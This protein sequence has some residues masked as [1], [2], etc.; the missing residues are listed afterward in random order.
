MTNVMGI[1]RHKTYDC[2]PCNKSFTEQFFLRKHNESE[3]KQCPQCKYE[4]RVPSHLRSHIEEVH[5]NF[6][7]Q[8][9]LCDYQNYR[10]SQMRK[11]LALTHDN[12]ISITSINQPTN[13]LTQKQD[14]QISISYKINTSERRYTE[15]AH[16]PFDK[17]YKCKH[18][19]A[20]YRS[21]RSLRKHIQAIHSEVKY[22]CSHCEYEA[23]R[24]DNLKL[25]IQAVHEK[26]RYQCPLCSYYVSRVSRLKEH[27]ALKH[28]SQISLRVDNQR[29]PF[30]AICELKANNKFGRNIFS[31]HY[32]SIK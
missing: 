16:K 30:C 32:F 1:R 25:H 13:H 14:T 24:L 26:L 20:Q 17:V 8:C 22:K 10:R 31:D 15:S 21:T 7:F 9:L 27:I 11:H 2:V 5:E 4:A 18:C 12:Q 23:C 28:D 3:H 19:D 29:T 6:K